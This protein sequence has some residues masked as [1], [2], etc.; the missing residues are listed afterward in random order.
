MK[1]IN[2]SVAL[3]YINDGNIAPDKGEIL[4][5][6]IL[7]SGSK[8]DKPDLNLPKLK[9]AYKSAT[10]FIEKV[11]VLSLVPSSECTLDATGVS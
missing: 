11:A 9:C 7:K 10:N 4:K 8:S 6:Y 2:F 5:D 1:I 3:N